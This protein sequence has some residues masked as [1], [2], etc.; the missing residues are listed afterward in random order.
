MAHGSDQTCQRQTR[1]RARAPNLGNHLIDWGSESFGVTLIDPRNI[2]RVALTGD[3]CF[4]VGFRLKPS[5]WDPSKVRH[6]LPLTNIADRKFP[7]KTRDRA[8]LRSLPDDLRI[9]ILGAPAASL[10]NLRQQGLPNPKALRKDRPKLR[11]QPLG[12]QPI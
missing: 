4:Y 9:S 10:G 6:T 1:I 5:K 12:V 8:S 11:N 2:G 7:K 3:C